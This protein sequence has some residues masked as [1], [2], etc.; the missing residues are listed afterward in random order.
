[1][2]EREKKYI[3]FDEERREKPHEVGYK[4]FYQYLTPTVTPTRKNRAI[5]S[6]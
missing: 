6:S 2:I 5:T 1:M 3:T 4:D